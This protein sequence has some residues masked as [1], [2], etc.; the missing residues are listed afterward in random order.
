V[1][2]PVD[3]A[4]HPSILR[5]LLPS[6]DIEL[7][8]RLFQLITL[9]WG[10]VMLAV[11]APNNLLWVA[12][13]V[14]VPSSAA[15]VG[16]AAVALWAWWQ[17]RSGRLWVRTFFVAQIVTLDVMWFLGAGSSG[18]TVVFFFTILFLPNVFSTG[19]ERWMLNG[20][21]AANVIWVY[22]AEYAHP[23][24]VV[25]HAT[26]LSRVLDITGTTL[27]A[28]LGVGLALSIV[29]RGYRV[30]RRRLV[31]ANTRLAEALTEVHTL[32][33]LLPVCAWCKRIRDDEGHWHDV[34]NYL[35]GRTKVRM[36]HSMCPTCALEF[37]RDMK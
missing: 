15:L 21:I 3:A 31:D 23:E 27:V 28:L 9:I 26:P 22:G 20:L 34:E 36:T 30:E 29:V 16:F 6:P 25:R 13:S 8:Q 7:E 32:R 37:E 11:V 1:N 35:L 10:G 2:A 24:W 33:G 18:A 4:P 14:R 5:W 19:R 17:S 12:E